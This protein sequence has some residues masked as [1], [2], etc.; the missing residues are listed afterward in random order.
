[1]KESTLWDHLRP[2]LSDQGKF[3]KTSDRFTPGIPDILGCWEGRGTALE[4]KE[5]K[6]VRVMKLKFRPG[7]L[8]WLRDWQKAG[9]I[10]WIISTQAHTVY[11]H[12][13]TVGLALELGM[14]PSTVE[15]RAQ[16][17]FKKTRNNSWAEFVM[18]LKSLSH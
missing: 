5:F 15:A 18:R 6:G 8:D 3:Q 7:Q 12:D 4:L 1:M 13:W 11:V 2:V 10:S 16:L 17:T 14:P 9:G